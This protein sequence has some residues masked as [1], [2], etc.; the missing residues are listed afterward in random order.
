MN[1]DLLFL[2]LIYSFSVTAL[3]ISIYALWTLKEI[4][5]QNRRDKVAKRLESLVTPVKNSKTKNVSPSWPT[6]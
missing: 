3:V 5:S 2:L 1:V 4:Q 6:R